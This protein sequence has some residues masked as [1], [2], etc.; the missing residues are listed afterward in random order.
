MAESYSKYIDI[1]SNNQIALKH[2]VCQGEKNFMFNVQNCCHMW[3]VTEINLNT[4]RVN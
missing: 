4:V 1:T 2:I 3:L